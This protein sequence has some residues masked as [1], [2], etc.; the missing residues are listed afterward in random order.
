MH[1]AVFRKSVVSQFNAALR[2][3][4]ECLERCPDR[5][6]DQPV[7]TL[8]FWEVVYHALCWTDL[9]LSTSKEAW[10]PPEATGASR[11]GASRAKQANA[12]TGPLHPTGIQE[13]WGKHPSRRFE[14]EELLRY[15]AICK[16]KTRSVLAA[17]T[18]RTLAGPSGFRW[19]KGPRAEGHLYNL[20]H[21]AG[22]V[23]QLTGFLWKHG[24]ATK[25]VR[26]AR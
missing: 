1:A 22:H 13:M 15:A 26:A 11:I 2:M 14:R 18:D 20:R 10:R 19:I 4:E 24:V 3:L 9:Y 6:W 16:K 5:L 7:G 25:W 23:G 17:E 12:L 8:P 21:L